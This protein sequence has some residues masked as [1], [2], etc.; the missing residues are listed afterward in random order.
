MVHDILI[1]T[2]SGYDLATV[3]CWLNS[4][5]RCGYEGRRVMLVCNGD[6]QL[7]SSLRER[8]C[9]VVTYKQDPTTGSS[10][11]PRESFVDEDISAERFYL[12]WQY[13]T[14]QSLD[15]CRYAISIDVRDAIFQTDPSTWLARHLGDKLLNVSSEAIAY[16][17][18]EW[19]RSSLMDNFGE[20]VYE[21]LR[22]CPVWNAGVIAG[23]ATY[24]RDLCLNVHLLCRSSTSAYSD[25]AALNTILSMEPYRRITKFSLS[26]DGWACHAGTLADPAMAE[27]H[28]NKLLEPAPV[29]DGR[30]VYTAGGLEYAVVH[31]YDRVPL[32][33]DTLAAEYGRGKIDSGGA[34]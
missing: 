11:H 19:N 25:Q 27:K 21:Q 34:L 4:L 20:A 13:L 8:H 29:F 30:R 15:N 14:S 5:D 1:G 2:I 3:Q 32:W 12:M 24:F 7:I 9:E 17:D 33:R 26:E 10:S 18:E 31:Q 6:A 23:I 28:R 22:V 16:E